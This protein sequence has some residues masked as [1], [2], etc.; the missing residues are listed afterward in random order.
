MFLFFVATT[1]ICCGGND[2]QM[3][4]PLTPAGKNRPVNAQRQQAKGL[5]TLHETVKP[6]S[7]TFKTP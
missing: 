5:S 6:V 7:Y 4:Q 1:L 2:R 3:Q